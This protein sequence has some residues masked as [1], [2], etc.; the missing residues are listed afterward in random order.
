MF[1]VM[2]MAVALRPTVFVI[3]IGIVALPVV[4]MFA[5]LASIPTLVHLPVPAAPA[6]I[7]APAF[8]SIPIA[9]LIPPPVPR[10][11]PVPLLIPTRTM[12]PGDSCSGGPKKACK[13]Y[14][15]LQAGTLA[16]GVTFWG[17]L[18]S[19][20]FVARHPGSRMSR[21]P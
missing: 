10:P 6:E 19:L 21:L 11:V 2:V 13:R 1:V 16:S 15:G 8:V 17:F 5:I 3:S 4:V 9:I 20:R 14:V 12:L 18:A 7:P